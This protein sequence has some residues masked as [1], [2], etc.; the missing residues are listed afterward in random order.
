M[1]RT[2]NAAGATASAVAL[3]IFGIGFVVCL[4]LSILFYVQKQGVMQARDHAQRDLKAYVTPQEGNQP[5]ATELVNQASEREDVQSVVG[6]LRQKNA[7]LRQLIASSNNDS[8]ESVRGQVEAMRKQIAANSALEMSD[9]GQA[10]LAIT[11]TL[12]REVE[13]RS[14]RVT[15]LENNLADAQKKAGEIQ[16]QMNDV[17]QAFDKHAQ[18]LDNRVQQAS[19]DVSTYKKKIDQIQQ[20]MSQ[21]LK[22]VRQGK[23][24]QIA[25]LQQ[26][27][28]KL[29]GQIDKLET[30][31]ASIREKQKNLNVPNVVR[32]DGHIATVMEGGDKVYIDLGREDH[33][34]KAMSFEVFDPD[35]L[36]KPEDYEDVRGKA[37]IEVIE[38]GQNTSLARIV[39]RGYSYRGSGVSEGDQIVNVAFQPDATY[40]FYVHGK[41][42]IEDTGTPTA[43]D[44]ERLQ[45]IIKR[46]GGRVSDKLDYDVDYVVVGKEPELPDQLPSD[47]IDPVLI[48]Q[49]AEQTERV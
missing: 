45:S 9:N 27:K 34:V 8:L 11:D 23:E 24:D 43:A 36:V 22:D 28:Q 42:D 12:L 48:R 19:D 2:R 7:E 37:T 15:Q 6:L 25:Q 20:E 47:V 4:V 35:T 21:R 39:R 33:L 17:R 30:E 14:E 26:D 38:V 1:A 44:R 5:W 40:T 13:A 46:W 41:F 16:K 3:T 18:D 29:Q 49:H 31:L 10:L 32:A